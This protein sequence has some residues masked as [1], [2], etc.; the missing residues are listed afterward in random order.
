MWRLGRNELDV[1]IT[2]DVAA[3]KEVVYRVIADFETYPQFI[4]EITTARREGDTYWFVARVAILTIPAR[5]RVTEQPSRS[6]RFELVEGPVDVLVGNW[7]LD[8]GEL[9]GH[10]RVTLTLHVETKSRGQWLLKTAARY[11]EGKTTKLIQAFSN[12]VDAVQHHRSGARRS[13]RKRGRFAGQILTAIDQWR[14]RQVGGRETAHPAGK[15]LFEDPHQVDTLEALALTVI[16]P[17]G[18]D[19]GVRGMGFADVAEVRSRY[20]PERSR[21]YLAALRAVDE[22]AR[23]RFGAKDFVSLGPEER[24][25]VLDAIRRGERDDATWG[26]VQPDKFFTALWEDVVF[27]YCTHQDTWRR[28]GWPGPS[29]D[30]GGYPDFDKPQHFMGGDGG[31]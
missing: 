23:F 18:F 26:D 17:D 1:S 15:R 6:V 21:L 31:D 24:E 3:P 30:S 29:F 22:M 4:N 9:P 20:Q 7:T 16:P 5:V 10:T 19:E 11:V 12:Q 2:H 14:S 28:I 27:L 13:P 8:D 25:R